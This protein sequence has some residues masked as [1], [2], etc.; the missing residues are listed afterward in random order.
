MMYN[1]ALGHGSDGYTPR[2]EIVAVQNY[3][4]P[5]GKGKTFGSNSGPIANA[6]LGGWRVD[7]IT[8]FETGLQFTALIA[9]YPSGYA[10]PSVGPT[11]P[12]RGILSPY[13]GAAHNRTQWYKGASTAALAAG[14]AQT[15]T[16]PTQNTFGNN[17]FNNLYG[18]IYINQDVAA[19][20]S[21]LVAE[22]YKFTLRAD[23]FN[24][25][26]HANLGLPDAN[27]TD[28]TAGKI[29]SLA[30]NAN[31]RRLQFALRMEF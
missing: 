7:G 29:T 20:K 16:L 9:A 4:I 26:N 23:A 11:F 21:V 14:T 28:A 6:I 27:I 3:E 18:P 2:S 10:Y 1:R 12:N 15:F 8:T 25:F 5:Y 13:E 31:M 24:V 30:V 19:M 17:G 22:K